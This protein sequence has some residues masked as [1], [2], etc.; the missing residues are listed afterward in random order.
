M[1]RRVFWGIVG[2][3]V[4]TLTVAGLTGAVLINR[5]VQDSIRSE[6]ERQAEA[7]ARLVEATARSPRPADGRQAELRSLLAVAAAVGGHDYIE[8]A[9]VGPGGLVTTSGTESVLLDQ[10]PVDI[11]SVNRRVQ[12]EAEVEGESVAAFLI[13][14]RVGASTIVVAIGTNLEIVPW[15]D[16]LL[17]FAWAIGLGVVLAALLAVWVAR[18]LA[19]RLDRLRDASRQMAAGNLGVRIDIG[20]SDEVSEVEVSFNE[21]AEG[22]QQARRREREFLVAVSHDLRT[23]LTTIRGYTEALG[24]DRVAPG[25]LPRV[26]GVIH[27][28]VD[29][30]G[31]LVEDLMLLSRIEAREFSLR[32]EVVDLAGHLSG[33]VEAFRGRAEAAGVALEAELGEVPEAMIDPDRIA[34]VVGNLLENALRYTPEAGTVRL[35]LK[36]SDGYARIT[37]EDDG[38]GIDPADLPHIFERLYVTGRYRPVRPEGSG[39]GLSI[40]KELVEAMAGSTE[41]ESAPNRGTSV[42]VLVPLAPP[43]PP[44]G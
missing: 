30:L 3:V 5:S 21:M 31:R 15:T 4:I 20:P 40:V 33:V 13:P 24:E 2:S 44:E 6:F 25:D 19:R 36:E 8:A 11:N 14:V 43:P 10:A 7:T 34:Q 22:V 32:P 16:V 28:E 29:R 38:S 39:L 9:L 12:F 37:V 17:R 18:F 42:S 35:G 23:P 1:R 26:A 27:R 41:V